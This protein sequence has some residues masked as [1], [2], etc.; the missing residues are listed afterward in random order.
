[1]KKGWGGE[2]DDDDLCAYVCWVIGRRTEQERERDN[3]F[4]KKKKQQNHYLPWVLEHHQLHVDL[5]LLFLMMDVQPFFLQKN[6]NTF[7][8]QNEKP[9]SSSQTIF[10]FS[11]FFLENRFLFF[12]LDIMYVYVHIYMVLRTY[13]FTWKSTKFLA[14]FFVF[15]AKNDVFSVI[16]KGMRKKIV[17][18]SC[19]CTSYLYICFFVF[20]FG[21]GKKFVGFPL[22]CRP[23]IGRMT[24]PNGALPKGAPNPPSPPSTPPPGWG[25]MPFFGGEGRGGV[26]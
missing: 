2:Y 18:K 10:F 9:T 13:Y 8:F 15:F 4:P 6:T 14:G 1:M 24:V 19:F 7:F 21:K 17:C 26:W 5:L 12:L 23:V 22:H 20:F 16:Y 3:V 11:L 25:Y